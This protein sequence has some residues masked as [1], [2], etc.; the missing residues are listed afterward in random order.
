MPQMAPYEILGRGATDDDGRFHL[1]VP[2]TA[3]SRFYDLIAIGVAPGFG[4]G[5]AELNPDAE[6]PEGDIRLRPEQL[7]R[8]R[9]VDVR[10]MPAAG[11]AVRVQSMGQRNAK[12]TWDGV[13]HWANSDP[14]EG[15]RAW[16]SPV[17]TDD[18]GRLALSGIG[19]DLSVALTV[20]DIRFARQ[21]IRFDADRNAVPKDKETTIALQP[22][23]IIEGR[24]LAADTGKPIPDAAIIV[25]SVSERGGWRT[26]RFRADD[27]GRFQVNPFPAG[28]FRVR[29]FPPEA[30]P[31]CVPAWS[32]PGPRAPSRRRS[33]S[34][35]PSAS[36]SRAR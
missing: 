25:E 21:D 9:L 5:W 20:H 35:Y 31:I 30:S 26:S 19:R 32:S 34:S 10:G 15:L 33:K 24:A 7:V 12:G 29:A 13:S 8:L 28:R 18:Q 4:I 3:S 27:Q 17:K 2:R 16:P 23:T 1:E 36:R 14:P 22:A 6:Q 11:V